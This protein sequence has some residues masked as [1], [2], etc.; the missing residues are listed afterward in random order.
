MTLKPE[1]I[2]DSQEIFEEISV[3]INRLKHETCWQHTRGYLG[4][5]Q[6]DFGEKVEFGPSLLGS[7]WI[8]TDWNDFIVKNKHDAT[9]I[10]T[11]DIDINEP[12]VIEQIKV[13]LDEFIG[14]SITAIHMDYDMLTLQ[15]SL[16]EELTFEIIP[17]DED[18]FPYWLI[19]F[20]DKKSL[21]VGRGRTYSY[22]MD[23]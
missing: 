9:L 12:G 23:K 18:D 5:Y 7:Y 17:T 10:D 2:I 6:L 1:G 21:K 3:I 16:G 19:L 15:L 4:V 22:Q 11:R 8:S 20:P 13:I 14:K